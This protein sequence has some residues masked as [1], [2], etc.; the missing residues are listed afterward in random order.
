MLKHWRL[1]RRAATVMSR[2]GLR[3]SLA[4]AFGDDDYGDFC[5][6]TL[7]EQEA[8]DLSRSR[9]F[10]QRPGPGAAF[11]VRPDL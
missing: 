7:E 2:L 8:V 5:W 10:E 4:A 9:R 6:R 1:R 11:G 3:T